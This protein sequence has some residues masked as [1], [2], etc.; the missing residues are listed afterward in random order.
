MFMRRHIPDPPAPVWLGPAPRIL[1]VKLASL[2]DM[3]LMMPSMHALRERYPDAQIDLLTT[4]ASA[5]LAARSRYFDTI[6]PFDKY[7]FDYPR[8]W[9]QHPWKSV[10]LMRTLLRLRHSRYDAVILGHHLTLAFGRWKYRALLRLLR[11]ETTIGLDNGYGHFLDV[12]VPDLGFG[13]C[14]EAEY[15]LNLAYASGVEPVGSERY[16]T[17]S[18]LDL[19]PHPRGPTS[20]HRIAL[21]PGS[22]TYSIARRW[23]EARFAGLAKKLHDATGDE[24]IVIA[25]EDERTLAENILQRCGAPS[26]LRLAA[27]TTLDDLARTLEAV[28]LF[29]ANDSFP[30]HFAAFLGLPVVAIFGPSNHA[31]W[32]PWA[33]DP[34]L[35]RVL[36]REEL[37]CSPC[38]YRGHELGTLKGCPPRPCLT[39]LSEGTV[40]RAALILRSTQDDPVSRGE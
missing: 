33:P 38:M 40:L 36:R 21:H 31:A 6:Y 19:E 35:V 7:A 39:G 10:P 28:D 30:M 13:A 37:P 15:A 17:A 16:S 2:G 26:W 27:T 34:N 25:G 20:F 18:D 1:V 9:L 23:P 12:R 32:R 14:H 24:I 4:Y 11:A 22:G 3:L 8:H 29:I 5:P